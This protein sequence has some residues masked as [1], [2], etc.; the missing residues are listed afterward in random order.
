MTVR[1]GRKLAELAVAVI[2]DAVNAAWLDRIR[3]GD[4]PGTHPV[5]LAV[6]IAA[7]GDRPARRL[8][9]PAVRRRDRR[10]SARR[11]G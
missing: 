5:S 8:R 10:S 11:C 4:T 7:L 1:M 3:H 2:D 9:R 6:A